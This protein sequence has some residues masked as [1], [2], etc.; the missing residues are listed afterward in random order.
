ME[1]YLASLHYLAVF[2]LAAL[3]VAEFV[4]LRLERG[5]PLLRLLGGVDLAYGLA[6]I[7]VVATGLLRV[8]LGDHPRPTGVPATSSG[9]RW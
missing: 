2:S 6:A 3:L 4:L 1:P 9:P 5:G 8:F 7:A